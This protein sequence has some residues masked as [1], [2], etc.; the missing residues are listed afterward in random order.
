MGR[1]EIEK[2]SDLKH[3]F[4]KQSVV[5]FSNLC[6]VCRTI[7]CRWIIVHVFDVNNYCCVVLI[8][9]VRCDQPQLILHISPIDIFGVARKTAV[10][11]DREWK[12]CETHT[13]SKKGRHEVRGKK[14][15]T[16]LFLFSHYETFFSLFSEC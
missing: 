13:G 6:F 1:I 2:R 5:L 7:E 15:I 3:A 12:E 11:N 16:F 4:G 8:Q 10:N 9:I 14:S